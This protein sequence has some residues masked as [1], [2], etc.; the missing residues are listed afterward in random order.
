MECG[1]SKGMT[2][3][4]TSQHCVPCEIGGTPLS[5]TEIQAEIKSL[6]SPEWQVVENK[7]IMKTFTCQ[8]FVEA[9]AFMKRIGDAAE[10]QGHHPDLKLH[11]Y[12]LVTVEW[13][14]HKIGGLHHND[15]IM[16]AK[17]DQA[18]VAG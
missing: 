2:E 14:T 7:K 15:F 16:A 8:N 9:L 5:P 18:F 1:T 13:W 11:D 10:Y 6:A 4:L 12:K 17:T 3:P